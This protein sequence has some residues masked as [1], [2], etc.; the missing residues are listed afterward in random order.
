MRRITIKDIAKIAGVSY[1]TVSRALSGSSEVSEQTRSRILEICQKEGYRANSLARSLISNKTNMLG[2]VVPDVANPFYA[3]LAFGIEKHA[4]E[5]GYN[6]MLSNS[7]LNTDH[8]RNLID[9]LI[10]HQADGIILAGSND[11]TAGWIGE[12][13]N[14]VPMVLLGD[15]VFAGPEDQFNTVSID[16]QTG[17]YLAGQYLCGLGHKKIAYLGL[18]T[19]SIAHRA[20]FSGFCTA[21]NEHNLAPMV[22]ENPDNCSSLSVGYRLGKQLLS[23]GGDCTAI[24][25][26]TDS[27]A[28]G[29]LQAADELNINIPSDFSLLGFDNITYSA[30]P[31][32]SITTIDQCK[33]TLAE[34]AVDLLISVIEGEEQNQNVHR[35]IEPK[36]IQRASCAALLQEKE[37]LKYRA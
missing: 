22:L 7:M 13:K 4:Y 23:R 2:L 11:D 6:I 14:T 3:E 20:R 10:S 32:I 24:F 5:N 18:R 28:L 35:I 8:T 12:Y 26:T 15:A 36:L 9:L 19:S 27:L 29:V 30:L 17:G 1:A 37:S 16:N 34:T 31:K 25:A 33:T 21:L